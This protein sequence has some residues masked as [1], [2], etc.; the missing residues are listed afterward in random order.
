MHELKSDRFDLYSLGLGSLLLIFTLVRFPFM[1]QFID[2]YYHLSSANGFLQSGGWTGW[3]WW[4]FAPAGRPQLYPPLYHFILAGLQKIGVSGL[5]ALRFCEVSV[6]CLFFVSFWYVVRRLAGS[7]CALFSLLLAGSFF[8][9]YTSTAIH[10]PAT[11]ALVFGLLT[12]YFTSRKQWL[13][14][15]LFLLLCFYTHSAVP[16]IISGSLLFLLPFASFRRI[17]IKENLLALILALPLL[18]HQFRFRGYVLFDSSQQLYFVHFSPA[19]IFF[20]FW[21]LLSGEKK[22]PVRSLFLGYCAV[23]LA[24]FWRYPYRFFSAQGILGLAL[25]SAWSLSRLLSVLPQPKKKIL[26]VSVL[27]FFSVFHPTVDLDLGR[28]GFNPVNSTYANFIFGRTHDL[29]EFRSVYV[30][31][32]LNPVFDYLKEHVARDQ[33]VVS[34]SVVI[35]QMSTA[36]TGRAN[37]SAMLREVTSGEKN[38]N[39]YA[40]AKLI[41]WL[42]TKDR[43]I[44]RLAEIFSWQKIGE[45]D[46]ALIYLSPFTQARAYPHQA[47][48]PFFMIFSLLGLVLV[49]LFLPLKIRQNPSEKPL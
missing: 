47:A 23:S 9:F 16:W 17:V 38:T 35:S 32:Q 15:G 33:I 8:S 1:P 6:P 28:P 19:L 37:S 45:T 27:V 29:L 20:T 21:A 10:I 14:A 40:P 49:L 46:I 24:V 30:P 4:D 11:L 18:V 36:F 13:K 48:V 7:V 25:I 42:K 34:N 41:V 2:A 22:D 43:R 31:D 39:P 3:S 26:F 5:N 12:W 44:N